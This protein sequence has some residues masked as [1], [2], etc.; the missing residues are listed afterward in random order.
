MD[1]HNTHTHNII[2]YTYL[3]K[4]SVCRFLLL[5]NL[6]LYTRAHI[7]RRANT[8]FPHVL[9]VAALRGRAWKQLHSMLVS[10]NMACRSLEE[11]RLCLVRR[12]ALGRVIVANQISPRYLRPVLCFVGDFYF[13]SL[14]RCHDMCSRHLLQSIHM[15]TFLDYFRIPVVK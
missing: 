15:P 9:C 14:V 10:T 3:S 6:I 2:C 11:V 12:R 1:T 8:N 7:C 5:L 13:Y 4:K